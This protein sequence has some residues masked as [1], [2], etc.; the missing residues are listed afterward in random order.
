[1]TSNESW[2]ICKFSKST[3]SLCDCYIS[4]N[5]LFITK[6][7]SEIQLIWKYMNVLLCMLI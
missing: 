6:A 7:L 5:C 2:K 4:I 1:M 3:T